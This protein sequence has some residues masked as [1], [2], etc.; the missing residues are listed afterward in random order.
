MRYRSSVRTSL[1]AAI[2]LAGGAHA[3]MMAPLPAQTRA[4]S[5][6]VR[7]AALDYI[8][9]WYEGDAVRMARALHPEL[10]KRIHLRNPES[11]RHWLDTQGKSRLVASTAHGGGSETPL[12]ERRTDVTVLDIFRDAATVRV[13]AGE[14]IDYLQLVR[15]DEGWV[16]VNVLWVLREPPGR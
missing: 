3:F 2:L 6:G 12:E 5:S 4:Y 16:I 15:E 11:E 13:D 1:P 8:E 9:G 7:A 10:V 14:W